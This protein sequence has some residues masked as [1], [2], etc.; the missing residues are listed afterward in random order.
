[1]C[2]LSH[3]GREGMTPHISAMPSEKAPSHCLRRKESCLIEAPCIACPNSWYV[4][5]YHTCPSFGF[6]NILISSGILIP[7]QRPP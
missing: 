6:N 3:S 7:K 2:D 5:P 4:A 1:M